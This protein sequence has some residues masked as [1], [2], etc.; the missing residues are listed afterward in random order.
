[1][2]PLFECQRQILVL[3]AIAE[4]GG[5]PV[6]PWLF[7]SA[8]RVLII[9]A[10]SR[11]LNAAS[12]VRHAEVNFRLKMLASGLFSLMVRVK[13]SAL[14]NRLAVQGIH[15]LTGQHVLLV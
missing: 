6:S 7:F 1:M 10:L 9:P 12:T 8:Q 15:S 5:N 13:L 3:R 11:Y 14:I 4:K 2:R